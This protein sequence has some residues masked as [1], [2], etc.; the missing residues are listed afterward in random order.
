VIQD[1]KAFMDILLHFNLL[2]KRLWIPDKGGDKT[3]QMKQHYHGGMW[4]LQRLVY[5]FRAVEYLLYAGRRGYTT[6]LG[7]IVGPEL[8]ICV[9]PFSN[10]TFSLW[11]VPEYE[12][13][14]L[15]R[16]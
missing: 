8:A 12:G 11:P 14:G 16:V 4:W 6:P 10:D 3:Q 5:E 2:E 9:Q 1:P 13:P 7:S 15:L